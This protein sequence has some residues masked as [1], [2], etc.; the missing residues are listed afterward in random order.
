MYQTVTSLVSEERT[1]G[2]QFLLNSGIQKFLAPKCVTFL[3]VI[4]VATGKQERENLRNTCLSPRQ[5]SKYI[6]PFHLLTGV[7]T[8]RFYHQTLKNWKYKFLPC[9]NFNTIPQQLT[10]KTFYVA[11]EKGI[12]SGFPLS[13]LFQE[14]DFYIKQ[15]QNYNL[16]HES[17]EFH[18]LLIL[19]WY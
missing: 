2:L 19:T 12:L 18:P 9:I 6:F 3:I 13:E 10:K 17:G 7:A 1:G 4:N 15:S 16:R 14:K 5:N 11:P 8:S